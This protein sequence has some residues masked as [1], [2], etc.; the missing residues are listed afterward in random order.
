MGEFYKSFSWNVGYWYSGSGKTFSII[1]PF[2]RQHTSKGFAMVVYDYKFPT[3]ARMLFY[4]Y[5][6][7][8]QAGRTPKNCKFLLSI[9]LM[10]NISRR[11]N[12][13]QKKYIATMGAASETAAT[14]IESLQKGKSESGGEALMTFSRLLP[15]TFSLL[16]SIFLFVI[17]M[18]SIRICLMSWLF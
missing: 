5:N 1:E 3:L 17:E 18:V 8:K 16:L 7:N 12:P 6:Y 13:I 2:I 15:K 14:L 10:W 9:L 4:H 11:V